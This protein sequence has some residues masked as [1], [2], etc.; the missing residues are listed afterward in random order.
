MNDGQHRRASGKLAH[1][2]GLDFHVFATLLF[3]GWSVLAGGATALL[4]PL[5]LTPAQQGYYYTFMAVLG[6]QIFFELGLNHVLTQLAS[7]NA[8]HL[9]READGRWRGP[10]ENQ[11]RIAALFSIS[12]RW[13]S[14][15]SAVFFVV[16]FVGGYLFFS[17]KEQISTAQWVPVWAALS[18]LTAVNLLFSA[19]LSIIEGLG[20]VGQVARLRLRQSAIGYVVLWLLLVSGG[21]L[22]S[23]VAVPATSAAM[24]FLWL[25]AHKR[26]IALPSTQTSSPPPYRWRRDIFPLQWRIAVS[27]ASGYFIFT[28]LVPMVF[29]RQGAAEAGKLGLALTIFSS[30]SSIGMSWVNA[31]LP[32][33]AK[34][35]ATKQKEQL[36]T[37][38]NAQFSRSTVATAVACALFLLC[39]Y[40]GG[41]AFAKIQERL[42][43]LDALF[44]LA[45]TTV[46]NSV[47]FSFAAY[48]RA[49][50]EE[51]LVAQSVAVAILMAVGIFVSSGTSLTATI[52]TYCAI[53]V[54]IAAPWTTFIFRR[55]R[56]RTLA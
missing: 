26:C 17:A 12:T 6:T 33:Y 22:W 46:V 40:V 2:I 30:I 32:E 55:Y 10:S 13:Y 19:R 7:H 35:I 52:A 8:A 49:H 25:R 43:S 53:T 15:A 36:D 51:P 44:I 21:N 42:P 56:Q 45:A 48:M 18:L 28:F 20:E 38:F 24:T 31:K 54:L 47:I 50:K 29:A 23:A 37:L 9:T 39:A 41:L 5:F 11:E 3:R 14:V 34:L 16:I 27:W 1:R 4:I